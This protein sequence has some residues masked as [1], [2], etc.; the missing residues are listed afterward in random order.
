MIQ[1]RDHTVIGVFI[2]KLNKSLINQQKHSF[3]ASTWAKADIFSLL[4]NVPVGYW[5]YKPRRENGN[6]R[7]GASDQN[8][9]I[10]I[11][12]HKLQDQLLP[13]PFAWQQGIF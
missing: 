13:L 8:S 7:I 10:E 12:H 11:Q 1:L 3:S 9:R 5:D 2:S 4:I 6:P